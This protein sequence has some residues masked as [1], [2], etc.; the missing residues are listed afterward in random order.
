MGTVSDTTQGTTE[1]QGNVIGDSN[2]LSTKFILAVLV[3]ILSFALVFVGDL[4]AKTWFEWA[5]VVT[6][7]YATGNVI[8]KFS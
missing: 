5:T 4:D 3:I 8:Q 1:Q 7:I 2:L 6:G